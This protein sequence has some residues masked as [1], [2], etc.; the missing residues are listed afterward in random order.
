MAIINDPE[1]AGEYE[2]YWNDQAGAWAIDFD[3]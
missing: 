2:A 1:S 3:W